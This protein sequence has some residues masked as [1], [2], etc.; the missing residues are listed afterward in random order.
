MNMALS[1]DGSTMVRQRRLRSNAKDG[2]NGAD[3]AAACRPL[4]RRL[5]G[6]LPPREALSS[7]PPP[8]DRKDGK[9]T[10]SGHMTRAC[11]Q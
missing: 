3:P 10:R 6:V 8:V 7:P 1:T 4:R 11:R 5:H 9:Q 2:I